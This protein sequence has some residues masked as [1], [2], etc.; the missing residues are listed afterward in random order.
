MATR[1]KWDEYEV[2]LLVYY[3][4]KIQDGLITFDSATAELSARLRRKAERKGL[5]IDNIYRNQNG[6]SMKL[7]NMQYLF[8]EGQKGLDCYS[9]MDKEIYEIYKND[10]EKYK[11]ILKK[12]LEMTD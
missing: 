1:I 2:A 12:A 3:Y 4:C 6:M 11:Q 10:N 9:R 7:G 5:V 8:T